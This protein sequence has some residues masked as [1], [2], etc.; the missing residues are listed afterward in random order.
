[1]RAGSRSTAVTAALLGLAVLAPTPG[2]ARAQAADPDSGAAL[3]AWEGYR[4]RGWQGYQPGFGSAATAPVEMSRTADGGWLAHR[5]AQGWDLYT[6]NHGW[7]HYTPG[8]GWSPYTATPTPAPASGPRLATGW[9]G[10]NPGAA[11]V[12]YAPGSSAV[13]TAAPSLVRQPFRATG[14][15]FRRPYHEPSTGRTVVLDKPWLPGAAGYEPR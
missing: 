7:S 5:P 8:E 13:R 11:W 2:T 12:D 15:Q 4:A 6:P 14:S 1:M 3:D 10:Y 9:I